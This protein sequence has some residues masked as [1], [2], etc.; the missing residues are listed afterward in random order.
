MAEVASQGVSSV[1]AAE[2]GE[3]GGAAGVGEQGGQMPVAVG[4][5]DE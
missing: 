2:R 4:D 1:L 5:R 3:E